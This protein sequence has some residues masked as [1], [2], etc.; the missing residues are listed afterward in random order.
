MAESKPKIN[1]K[2]CVHV[3]VGNLSYS[4][5]VNQLQEVF[6]NCG[7]IVS[8]KIATHSDN[9]TSRGFGFIEFENND[10]VIGAIKLSGTE[11]N[12][13]KIRVDYYFPNH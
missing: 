12:E 13:R 8:V 1:K 4:A 9:G 6:Q 7:N 2:K 10:G 5:T 11:I 3:F